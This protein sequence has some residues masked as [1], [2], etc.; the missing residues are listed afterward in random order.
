MEYSTE[1]AIVVVRAVHNDNELL[2]GAS[3]NGNHFFGGKFIPFQRT[4]PIK[5]AVPAR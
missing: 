5:P 1:Y 3:K 4:K 2:R